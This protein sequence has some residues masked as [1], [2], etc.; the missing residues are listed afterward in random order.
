MH[1][2]RALTVQFIAWAVAVFALLYTVSPPA[3]LTAV[4][5]MQGGIAA[6]LALAMGAP[7]WWVIIH[8]LFSPL[9]VGARALDIAPAWYLFAFIALSAIFWSTFRTRVP[10]FLTNRATARAL[11]L[12][13][14]QDKPIHLV[15]LGCGTGS[16]LRRL[17]MSRPDCRFTGIENAPLPWL[18]AHLRNRHLPNVTIRRA[19]LW[20]AH[21]GH[22][23]VVYAFL[24]P[25]PMP[26]LGR[27]A[28]LEMR[29]G[30]LLIANSF[31]IPG[32]SA[33]RIVEGEPGARELY[34]YSFA[35]RRSNNE[36]AATGANA[37][38]APVPAA[39]PGDAGGL[40]A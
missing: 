1:L 9:V 38:L 20:S 35:C 19:D 3:G 12:T 15:D 4:V 18:I 10:L 34:V 33:D 27:K 7:R 26:K 8:L 13:L 16:L 30:A 25:V 22:F 21:L 40:V 17:A 11:L 32:L 37:E 31:E 36:P 23:D 5:I 24:S 2:F 28:A 29:P 14:P 39:L 6:A